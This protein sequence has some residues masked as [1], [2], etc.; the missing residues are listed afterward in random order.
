M[1]A[2]TENKKVSLSKITNYGSSGDHDGGDDD[3]SDGYVDSTGDYG[4]G[5]GEDDDGADDDDAMLYNDRIA[6]PMLRA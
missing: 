4:E 2:V 3:S 6:R 5:G 1:R